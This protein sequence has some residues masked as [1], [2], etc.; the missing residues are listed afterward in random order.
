MRNEN[1]IKERIKKLLRLGRSTNQAEAELA[2]ERAFELAQKHR[3]SVEDLALEAD[4]EPIA[5]N[6][7]VAGFRISYEQKLSCAILESYYNVRCV[8]G[9]PRIHI[10]GTESDVEIAEYVL[11]F[12][13]AAIRRSITRYRALELKARRKWNTSK[14]ANYI[15]GFIC[16]VD[17]KLRQSAIKLQGDTGRE[18]VAIDP[19]VDKAVEERF[20]DNLA[21]CKSATP[22][23]NQT[24]LAAGWLQGERTPIHQPIKGA[25]RT[26]LN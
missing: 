26:A 8:I 22:Q 13:V 1:N 2:L 16:A 19:R 9:R 21:V 6:A 5:E 14:R 20:G 17:A 10:F 3:L 23:K 18:I 15:L 4:L 24:A 12:L 25:A 11:D 7:V